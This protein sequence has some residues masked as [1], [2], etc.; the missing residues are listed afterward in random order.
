MNKTYFVYLPKNYLVNP[1]IQIGLG[2]LSLATYAKELEMDIEIINAQDRKEWDTKDIPDQS[3]VLISACLVD[4]PVLNKT[5]S[6]LNGRGCK[7]IVGGPVGRSPEKVFGAHCVVDGPGEPVIKSIAN[8]VLPHGYVSIKQAL[9]FNEYPIP[10]RTLLGEYQGGN[11]FHKRSKRVAEQSTTLLTSRGCMFKC[12]FC[13]SGAN[14]VVHNYPMERISD[15]LYKILE[16]GIKSVRISD[17]NILCDMDR[18]DDL[19]IQ[20]KSYGMKWRASLRTKPNDIKLYKRMKDA[21][22]VE[23]SFGIESGDDNVLKI[24]RKA[25]TVE[26]N[27]IAVRNALKAGISNVRALM[28]MSTPGETKETLILNQEWVS[29]FPEI[30]V[31]MCS[32]YPFPGTDVYDHP[33]KYGVELMNLQNPNIYAFRPDESKAESRIS[34]TKGLSQLELTEQFHKMIRYLIDSGQENRG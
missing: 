10:D 2:L 20:L 25:N 7:V 6:L 3:L 17:D 13:S 12:A 30:T 15:E 5:I 27:T 22:C 9:N 14:P 31:C 8:D 11:I 1:N 23:L 29:Q 34:I 4:I 19:L 26:D 32:F 28:M 18:F 33:F 21:G 16:L 24:L